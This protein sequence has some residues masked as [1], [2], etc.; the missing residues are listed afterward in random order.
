MVKPW[1][2]L[3]D[4]LDKFK[5]VITLCCI[6]WKSRKEAT[7]HQSTNRKRLVTSYLN[8]NQRSTGKTNIFYRR[9][10]CSLKNECCKMNFEDDSLIYYNTTK[11]TKSEVI[12]F[13]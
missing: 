1:Y 9:D 3:S 2:I 6:K 10:F 7:F 8:I 13:K 11:V 12:H 5:F 4:Q